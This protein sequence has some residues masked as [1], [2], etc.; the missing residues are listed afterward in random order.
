MNDNKLL[1]YTTQIPEEKTITEIEAMLAKMGASKV[2]KE[3]DAGGH[4]MCISF[5]L[6]TPEGEIP[7]RLPMNVMA[8]QQTL[9]NQYTSRRGR[10][11]LTKYASLEQAHRT[12]WRIIKCWVE[13][14]LAIIRTKM[15]TVEQVFLP[16]AV[17]H[18]DGR[19][20]YD[21]YTAHP[22]RFLLEA[23]QDKKEQEKDEYR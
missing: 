13:A 14:Q 18:R 9:K 20:L 12:G 4:P 22:K 8:V 16:Y 7:F 21:V 19:T 17:I 3:Y 6:R 5:M 15:V 11:G 23:G 2:M 1:N 10:D